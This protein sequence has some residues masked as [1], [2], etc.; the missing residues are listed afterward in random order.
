MRKPL[1]RLL[2]GWLMMFAGGCLILES[3]LADVR[4]VGRTVQVALAL[5]GVTLATMGVLLRRA[6]TRRP[7]P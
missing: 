6:A 5:A 7:Q 2:L 1:A 4:T 3:G